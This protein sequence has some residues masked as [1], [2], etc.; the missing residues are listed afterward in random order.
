MIVVYYPKF[1]YMIEVASNKLVDKL[2]A[3]SRRNGRAAT[4]EQL[5]NPA[6]V[7]QPANWCQNCQTGRLA[8]QQGAG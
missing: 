8:D 7:C 1:Y 6:R 5:V 4:G 2:L 3:T